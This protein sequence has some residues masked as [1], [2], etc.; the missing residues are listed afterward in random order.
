[1]TK[2]FKKAYNDLIDI[3]FTDEVEGKH[4]FSH[5]KVVKCKAYHFEFKRDLVG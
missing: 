5:E 2:D 3:L 4:I 1:M